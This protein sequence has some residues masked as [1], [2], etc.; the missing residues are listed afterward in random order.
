MVEQEKSSPM[1]NIRKVLPLTA[2]ALLLISTSP[3]AFGSTLTVTL[4]PATKVAEFQA[5]SSTTII[6]TYPA[7]SSMSN[8]LK[9][10]NATYSSQGSFQH[11]SGGVD[12]LQTSFHGYDPDVSLNN[13]SVSTSYTANGNATALVVNKDT[14]ITAWVTNVF[15]VQNGTVK[16]DLRWRSFVVMGALNLN[17]GDRMVDVN[18]AGSAVENSLQDHATAAGFLLGVFGHSDLW[19]HPTLN[20]SAL[21]SPLSTW[22][23]NYDSAT[24]TTTFSKVISGSYSISSS[25]DVNGQKYTFSAVSDPSSTIVVAGYAN[26]SGDSLTMQAP[27]ASGALG[28]AVVS[29][30]EVVVAV[31]AV[32]ALAL[33]ALYARSRSKSAKQ[34]A[35]Q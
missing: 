31:A 2:L 1:K 30:G 7:N 35:S 25:I 27:P 13:M 26:A 10:V 29:S 20:F 17:L 12:E 15:S 5:M 3:I 8:A 23:K 32:A 4:N 24:N 28:T 21:D 14:N 18:L 16:A 33:L 6:M 11:G 34:P 9:G 19:Q 22:T